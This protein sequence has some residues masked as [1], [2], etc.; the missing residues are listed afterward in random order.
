MTWVSIEGFEGLYEI[1]DEGL[2]R[3]LPRRVARS[4]SP[5]F[6]HGKMLKGSKHVSGHRS[7]AL[8][9]AGRTRQE[10]IHRLVYEHFVGTIPEGMEVRHMNG[11]PD[12]NRLEN[13]RIGTRTQQR[14]DD[15]R[16][17]VH[18]Q[19]KQ[20][21][22][23]RGHPLERPFLVERRLEKGH[24]ICRPCHLAGMAKAHHGFTEEQVQEYADRKYEEMKGAT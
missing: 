8:K 9:E 21:H 18:H 11:I 22:C 13:L 2:V 15:V 4:S 20:T 12:D 19:S 24:R 7:V 23:K 3:S 5:Q 10:Y 1:S 14:L 6:I 17:G 16:N